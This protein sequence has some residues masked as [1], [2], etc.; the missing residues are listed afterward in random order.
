MYVDVKTISPGTLCDL[1]S[2][3]AD[4]WWFHLCKKAFN[5]KRLVCNEAAPLDN[6]SDCLPTETKQEYYYCVYFYLEIR[7]I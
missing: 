4:V 1:Q 5:G 3:N 2:L 7:G 6:S